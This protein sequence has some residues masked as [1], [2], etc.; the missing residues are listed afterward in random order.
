M[1]P[2]PPSPV[3]RSKDKAGSRS[4]AAT[5]TVTYSSIK[6]KG[7]QKKHVTTTTAIITFDRL[8]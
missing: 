6:T 2:P 4:I 3:L 7:R 8:S 5:T 1:S